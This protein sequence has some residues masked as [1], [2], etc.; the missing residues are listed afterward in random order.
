[1][2]L[3]SVR[4][5]TRAVE[6]VG[7]GART[8]ALRVCVHIPSLFSPSSLSFRRRDADAALAGRART[9]TRTRGSYKG[10]LG[11]AATK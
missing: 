3:A 4:M 7:S 1:V 5:V 9:H 2:L 10:I 6:A 8:A 11:R